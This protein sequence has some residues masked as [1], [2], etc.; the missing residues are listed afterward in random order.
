MF[1]SL[2]SSVVKTALTPVAVI[3]DAV[4]IVKG[5]EPNNT[6]DLLDSAAEDLKDA[7]DEATGE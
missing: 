6:K 2:I 4:D 3:K 5:E 7:V 1:G